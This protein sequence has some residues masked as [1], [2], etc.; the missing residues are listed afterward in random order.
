MKCSRCSGLM[1][2][3]HFMDFEGGYREMWVTSQRCLNCGHVYDAVVEHNRLARQ[4]KVLMFS[5][6]E[7][8]YQDEEVHLGAESFIKQAA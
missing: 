6:S 3:G 1:V 2:E 7:P 5:S 4:E 8:D